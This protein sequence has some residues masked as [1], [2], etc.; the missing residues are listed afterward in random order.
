MITFL[1]LKPT[2][3]VTQKTL[4]AH[5]PFLDIRNGSPKKRV[6]RNWTTPKTNLLGNISRTSTKRTNNTAEEYYDR[7]GIWANLRKNN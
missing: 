5:T 1:C 7:A 6:L 4:G 2:L 3:D